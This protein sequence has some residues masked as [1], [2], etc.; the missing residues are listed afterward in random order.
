MLNMV[1][2]PVANLWMP[3][4]GC[5]VFG[6][7]HWFRASCSCFRKWL[8]VAAFFLGW[9]WLE[10]RCWRLLRIDLVRLLRLRFLAVG[11]FCPVLDSDFI[12][13]GS[14]L[15]NFAAELVSASVGAVVLATTILV[16]LD[17]LFGFLCCC[18]C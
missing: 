6:H 16:L 5:L 11:S 1:I 4:F 17:V 14:L 15:L 13:A 8:P 18:G 9:N 7:V 12:L 2:W 3:P 10:L